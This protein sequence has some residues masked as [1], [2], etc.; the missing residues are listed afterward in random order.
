MPPKPINLALQGGG[1]HG[2]F[3]WGVIDALLEDGRVVIEGVSGT[4]AG[5]MNAVVLADGMEVGGPEQARRSLHDF[6]LAVSEAARFSPIQRTPF[7]VL[8]GNWSLD[9]SPSYLFFDLVSRVVSPYATNPLDI[10]PLRDLLATRVDFNRVHRCASMKVFVSATN[11]RTG[12][13]RVFRETE[14]TPEAVMASA[15]LPSLFRAVEI[16]GEAYW[17]GGYMGNPVLYPLIY[18]CGSRDIVIVQ[19]NPLVRDGVPITAQEINNRMNEITFNASLIAELRAIDFVT[20]LLDEG[21]LDGT[22]YKRMLIHAIRGDEEMTTLT[23]SSKLNAEWSF[24]CLLRDIGRR[25]A[26]TWLTHHFDDLGRMST[27]D[28]KR[29]LAQKAEME[30]VEES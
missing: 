30:E 8:T 10:N 4:S 28:V 21:S 29:T 9:H 25:A 16:D 2:A 24:L 23:A 6:W 14:V 20:R 13:A 18:E 7:D 5:A 19:I 27:I 17:D 3:T 22:R 11:V 12:R 1:A 15:C 26:Q